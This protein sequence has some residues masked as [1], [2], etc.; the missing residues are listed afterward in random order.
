MELKLLCS[1]LRIKAQFFAIGTC[2]LK[3]KSRKSMILAF[4][5]KCIYQSNNTDIEKSQVPIDILEAANLITFQT[6][7]SVIPR[8]G[9][10]L[11][12]YY[13]GKTKL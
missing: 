2:C 5:S 11:D 13:I 10:N 3:F 4:N 12:Q 6:E 7:I 1:I 8:L 9:V